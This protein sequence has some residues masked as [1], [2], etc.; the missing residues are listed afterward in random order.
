MPTFSRRV[1][2]PEDNR[3]YAALNAKQLTETEEGF[4]IPGSSRPKG[5]T[6]MMHCTDRDFPLHSK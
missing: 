3:E 5:E 1:T 6:S 2:V 4:L